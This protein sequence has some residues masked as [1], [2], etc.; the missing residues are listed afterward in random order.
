MFC[1]HNRLYWSFVNFLIALINYTPWKINLF[2]AWLLPDINHSILFLRAWDGIQ[3]ERWR[4]K[5]FIMFQLEGLMG[6]ETST[7]VNK[8]IQIFK[9]SAQDSLKYSTIIPLLQLTEFASSQSGCGFSPHSSWITLI[10]SYLFMC[11]CCICKQRCSVFSWYPQIVTF[12]FI[13]IPK[14]VMPLNLVH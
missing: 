6:S 4:E 9:L 5:S 14:T 8:V 12:G 2:C 10:S 11:V 13:Y 1:I 3:R 7:V